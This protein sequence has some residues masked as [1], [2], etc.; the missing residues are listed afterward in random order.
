[1]PQCD[2]EEAIIFSGRLLFA[3]QNNVAHG[4]HAVPSWLD[5]GNIANQIAGL[6]EGVELN[7]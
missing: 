1:M 7:Q 2:C 4:L 6:A 5:V 3:L